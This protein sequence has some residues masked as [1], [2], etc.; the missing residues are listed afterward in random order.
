MTA[1]AYT[2]RMPAGFVGQISRD[3]N[4]QVVEAELLD[5]TNTPAS[6]G[7]PVK[8][9]S[10]KIRGF[11]AGDTAAQITGFLVRGYPVQGSLTSPVYTYGSPT[12]VGGNLGAR[13]RRGYFFGT[14][15]YGTPAVDG[16]VYVR[17]TASGGVRSGG[18]VGDLEATSDSVYNSAVTG[19]R[20]TGSLSSDG[21]TAEI[22]YNM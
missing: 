16:V 7:V 21:T 3:I 19:A 17:V 11:V 20:W 1:Q 13:M 14:C 10:S 8:T 4:G 15:A 18:A 12:P 6:Y 22:A 5:T 9:T 2:T